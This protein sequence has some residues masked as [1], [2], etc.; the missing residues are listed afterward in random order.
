MSENSI[1]FNI[2]PCDITGSS[3]LIL[4]AVAEN[5]LEV[6]QRTNQKPHVNSIVICPILQTPA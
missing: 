4:T 5:Q 1:G 6:G 3:L 2:N